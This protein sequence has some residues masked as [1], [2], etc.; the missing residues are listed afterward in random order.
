LQPKRTSFCLVSAGRNGVCLL[1]LH[2]QS[3]LGAECRNNGG[4][5]RL[6]LF[7]RSGDD[8]PVLRLPPPDSPKGRRRV[9]N[10]YGPA[11]RAWPEGTAE[12]K[13]ALVRE[14]HDSVPSI[15]SV[16]DGRPRRPSLNEGEV[17]AAMAPVEVRTHLGVM[18]RTPAS[19]PL[20]R[21]VAFTPC[22]PWMTVA[23]STLGRSSHP[24]WSRRGVLP[25]LGTAGSEGPAARWARFALRNII[26]SPSSAV[27][28]VRF[29]RRRR[30]MSL[31]PP[32]PILDPARGRGKRRSGV[33][34]NCS[35]PEEVNRCPPPARHHPPFSSVTSMAR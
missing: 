2:E 6:N 28:T 25:S 14:W 20:A 10:V 16:P 9:H 4:R 15:F 19:A 32:S 18:T 23:G 27:R 35:D 1:A 11:S 17:I 13:L 29:K 3:G 22:A 8:P 34:V 31:W 5:G 7:L 26:A 21:L 12:V 33:V 24:Q 30:F